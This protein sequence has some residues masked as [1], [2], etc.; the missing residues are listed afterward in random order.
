VTCEYPKRTFANTHGTGEI[1]NWDVT[2]ES[3]SITLVA[4]NLN[5][6]TM[7]DKLKKNTVIN[8]EKERNHLHHI[9][10]A[11]EIKNLT[12]RPA[13]EAFKTLPHSYQLVCT[14]STSV[15]EI[16]LP[17]DHQIISYDFTHLN[18]V[19]NKPMHLII[20]KFF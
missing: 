5:S 13:S 7:S 15:Q 19:D 3:G 6:N 18:Q 1:S 14:N 10:Q 4:F 9:E 17:F 12:I 16:N 2:D 20:G 11:Y 8:F